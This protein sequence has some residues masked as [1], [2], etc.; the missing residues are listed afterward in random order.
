MGSPTLYLC[1]SKGAALW[2]REKST[3]GHKGSGLITSMAK[4]AHG[5]MG[6]AFG[7]NIK[8]EFF[9][10][11]LALLLSLQLKS[12]THGHTSTSPRIDMQA[13]FAFD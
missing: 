9:A 3:K 4:E 5:T 10:F 12:F 2:G 7:S 1:C 6:L 13:A 8:N 11:P